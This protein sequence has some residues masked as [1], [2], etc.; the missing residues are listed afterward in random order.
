M[1]KPEI[2]TYYFLVEPSAKQGLWKPVLNPLNRVMTFGS[3]EAA[4]LYAQ[5]LHPEAL[6]RDIRAHRG[7]GAFTWAEFM[8]YGKLKPTV[9][10]PLFA[11]DLPA[12]ATQHG[13]LGK[14]RVRIRK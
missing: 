2:V 11:L 14:R 1:G 8:Y 5:K 12:E 9:I 10:D 3:M 4:S 6:I 13:V 7:K